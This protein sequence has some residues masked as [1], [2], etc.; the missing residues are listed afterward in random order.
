[1]L[2]PE[3]EESGVVGLVADPVVDLR[4]VVGSRVGRVLQRHDHAGPVREPGQVAAV[5]REARDLARLRAWGV[6][7]EDILRRPL[8]A[9]RDLATIADERDAR[10]VGRPPRG[11]VLGG[12]VRPS[13]QIGA[14]DRADE[15]RGAIAIRLDVHPAHGVRDAVAPGRDDRLVDERERREVVGGQRSE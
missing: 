14:I 11:R 4:R 2:T 13:D 15:D 7:E 9:L 12:A 8:L 5:I 3:I 6:D 10:A 1:M